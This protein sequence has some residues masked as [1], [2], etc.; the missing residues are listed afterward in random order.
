MT[1]WGNKNGIG[2]SLVEGLVGP[3]RPGWGQSRESCSSG[4]LLTPERTECTEENGLSRLLDLALKCVYSLSSV[5]QR[6]PLA[7]N[8]AKGMETEVS[9]CA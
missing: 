6:W 5:K 2:K 1:L 9:M 4:R 8:D 3:R 7:R